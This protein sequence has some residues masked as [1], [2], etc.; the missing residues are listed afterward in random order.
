MCSGESL[1]WFFADDVNVEDLGEVLKAVA[2]RGR[3]SVAMR[4]L[5]SGGLSESLVLCR[6]SGFV[7]SLESEEW[8]SMSRV[9]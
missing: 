7:P 5:V 9:C 3:G 1:T 6:V 8:L 2:S 4:W